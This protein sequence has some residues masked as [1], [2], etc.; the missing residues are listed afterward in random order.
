MAFEFAPAECQRCRASLAD[1]PECSRTRRQVIEARPAPPPLVTEYQLVSKL[2]RCCGARSTGAAA[3]GDAAAQLAAGPGSPVR[4]G[5]LALARCVLLTCAHFLP[6]GR[7][8]AL[9][10]ALSG[11]RLSTGGGS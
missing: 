4:V 7:A 3:G 8:A 9:L 11:L 10:A 6:V 5:P 2:C 1:A